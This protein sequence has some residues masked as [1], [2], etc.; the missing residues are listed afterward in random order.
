[1][2]GLNPWK[3]L[4]RFVSFEGVFQPQQTKNRFQTQ[5][6]RKVSLHPEEIA[7]QPINPKQRSVRL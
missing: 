5:E 6:V 7:E 1:M 4:I 2:T 3:S